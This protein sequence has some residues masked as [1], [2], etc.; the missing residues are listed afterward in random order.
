MGRV[1]YSTPAF[2]AARDNIRAM[3]DA[4][5]TLTCRRCG[6]PIP[7][8]Q[9]A[10]T[11]HPDPAIGTIGFGPEHASCNRSAG[12]KIRGVPASHPMAL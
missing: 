5:I 9:R 10:D 12:G 8:G 3:Q 11:G 1:N 4:G 7:P 6:K 2:R